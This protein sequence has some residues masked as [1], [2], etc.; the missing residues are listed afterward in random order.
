MKIHFADS[1]Q[2]RHAIHGARREILLAMSHGDYAINEQVDVLAAAQA[3][4]EAGGVQARIYISAS[5][6]E[7]SDLPESHLAR[8]AKMG[9]AIHRASARTPRMA[10]IDRST[11][12]LARNEA[13]YSEGALIGRGLPVTSM[14]VGSLMSSAPSTSKGLDEFS[15]SCRLDPLSREVL[16]QLRLGA[17]DERAARELGIALRTYRR[18]VA[19]LMVTLNAESRFQAGYLAAERRWP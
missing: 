12:I 7:G 13:D 9:V 5:V 3:A 6:R 17:T 19:R 15:E 2:I 11:V 14:L 18:I 1:P 10:I 8:L 16:R 4:S